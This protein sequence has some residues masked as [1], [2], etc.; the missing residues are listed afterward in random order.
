MKTPREVAAEIYDVDAPD[1]V[2]WR[3]YEA[4]VLARDA[5]HAEVTRGLRAVI[6]E[7]ARMAGSLWQRMPTEGT[8]SDDVHA[9]WTL[10]QRALAK[11][12]TPKPME[13][14]RCEGSGYLNSIDGVNWESGRNDYRPLNRLCP[15]CDGT[16]RDQ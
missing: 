1:H 14:G 2:A 13:C 9:L 5:E 10:L 12:P 8:Y 6:E 7:G 16:G 4:I 15:D 3:A 11:I